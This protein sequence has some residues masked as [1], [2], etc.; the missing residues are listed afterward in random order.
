[1]NHPLAEGV[2]V[3]AHL[4]PSL[5]QVLDQAFLHDEPGGRGMAKTR[6]RGTKE[7]GRGRSL[8]RHS[9]QPYLPSHHLETAAHSWFRPGL[10]NGK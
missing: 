6:I 1:M 3:K 4:H 8:R 5:L 2:V 10:E 9:T 7:K